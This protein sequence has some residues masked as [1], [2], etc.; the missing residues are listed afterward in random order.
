MSKRNAGI[1]LISFMFTLC[2]AGMNGYAQTKV[3]K[4]R[5][6]EHVMQ[7]LQVLSPQ[8]VLSYGDPPE[9][10][11][12]GDQE[13]TVNAAGR[14]RRIPAKYTFTLPHEVNLEQNPKLDLGLLNKVLDAYHSQ[15]DGP[16]FK[17]VSSRWGLHI[18]PAQVRDWSG[19]FVQSISILDTVITVPVER[20]TPA[21]HFDAICKAVSNASTGGIALDA[22]IPWMNQYF[23][24]KEKALSWKRA[25]ST[26]ELEEISFSWGT[27]GSIARDAIIDLLEHSSSTLS[28]LVL[29][30]PVE[31]H[32]VF[33]ML[34]VAIRVVGPDGK[35]VT[36][37]LSHDRE[38]IREQ[39]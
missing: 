20:R 31:K 22:H 8:P 18:V 7:M 27:S 33:N 4:A 2:L 38:D 34:P 35:M 29:C 37:A 16:R 24:P 3:E 30:E 28:W 25:P 17:V 1:Y 23:L 36:T 19:R 10:S 5:P 6:L 11:W 13:R 39:Y 32:C 9:L 15:T 12:S 14:L 21:G 26:R